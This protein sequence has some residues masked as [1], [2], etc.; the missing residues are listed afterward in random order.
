MKTKIYLF[1][2]ILLCVTNKVNL[3]NAQGESIEQT[4]IFGSRIRNPV[5]TKVCYPSDIIKKEMTKKEISKY[6]KHALY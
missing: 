5:G 3:I 6:E 2:L 4:T 1:S